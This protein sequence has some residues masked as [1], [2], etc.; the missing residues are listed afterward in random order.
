LANTQ[1]WHGPYIELLLS[2]NT[3]PGSFG[4]VVDANGR[5]GAT[6][7]VVLLQPQSRGTVRLVLRRPIHSPSQ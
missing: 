6:I 5:S 3:S 2:Y 1:R 7:G 4:A